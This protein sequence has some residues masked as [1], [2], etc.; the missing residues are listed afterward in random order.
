MDW[1]L[2]NI[3]LALGSVFLGSLLQAA[4]GLGAGL[5]IAPLLAF[6]SFSLVPGPM[7]FGS[8]ALSLVMTVRG[9]GNIDFDQFGYLVPGLLLGTLLAAAVVASIPF[10]RLGLLFGV[11]ILV[12]VLISLFAR[13]VRIRGS[14]L[15]LV[16]ALSG[17]MGTSAGV[18][19]PVL[20]LL[21]QHREGPVLRGTLAFLY[22]VSSIMMLALLHLA[23]R[24]SMPELVSGFILMPG[25]IAGYIFSGR[26]AALVDA[27]YAR[28][29]ILVFATVSAV[30]LILR[31]L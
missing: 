2:V 7:I 18:G 9:W 26:L 17:V 20:A 4:T 10:S 24:F 27:G 15:I 29:A 23:G 16:G 3:A 19:A 30:L 25:F 14:R 11:L 28:L 31:S 22:L 6:I 21:Y 13:Q 8:I 5:I 12:A 1:N